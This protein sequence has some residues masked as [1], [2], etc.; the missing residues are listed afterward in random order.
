MRRT[1]R[2]NI[3]RHASDPKPAAEVPPR[4]FAATLLALSIPVTAT[5]AGVGDTVVLGVANLGVANGVLLRTWVPTIAVNPLRPSAVAGDAV[6]P[7]AL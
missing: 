3:L 1:Y 6:V 5:V 7:K 2:V 4:A